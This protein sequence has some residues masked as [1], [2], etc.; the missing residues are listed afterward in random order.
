M[1]EVK[2][3]SGEMKDFLK[4]IIE[5]NRHIQAQGKKPVASEVIGPSGL[6]KTSVAI[7]MAEEYDLDLVKLN[8]AQIEEL[9][10]LVGFPVRQFQMYKEKQ[11]THQALQFVL[12]LT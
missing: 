2:L 11:V 8:L 7:Q 5:N 4:H 10:D 6:G 1:N 12:S 3:D 9:G